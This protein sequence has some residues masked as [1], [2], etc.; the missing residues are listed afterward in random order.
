MIN[1]DKS[2]EFFKNLAG[3]KAQ[4]TADQLMRRGQPFLST[5]GLPEL[6]QAQ[7]SSIDDSPPSPEMVLAE[8]DDSMGPQMEDTPDIA[9]R[10]R[11]Q[12]AGQDRF[13]STTDNPFQQVADA[14]R[15]TT[16]IKAETA[17]A[18]RLMT[19]RLNPFQIEMVAEIIKEKLEK[20]LKT[21][22]ERNGEDP[23]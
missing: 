10:Q 1:F 18:K 3:S 8:S 23:L 2:A 9:K 22:R 21:D 7:D 17:S 5:S 16:D 12:P 15:L 13:S 6:T 14:T 19:R 4:A 11:A 20:D